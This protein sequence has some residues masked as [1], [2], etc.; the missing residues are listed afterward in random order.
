MSV[1]IEIGSKRL[2]KR[3]FAET[4][5][6]WVKGGMMLSLNWGISGAGDRKSHGGR[7]VSLTQQL[8][9]QHQSAYGNWFVINY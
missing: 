1:D 9:L 8:V 7:M 3:M 2:K 5:E 6:V 4:E